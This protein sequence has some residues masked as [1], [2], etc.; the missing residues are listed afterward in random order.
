M[1]KLFVGNLSWNATEDDLK[2]HFESAGAVVS[3][4]IVIDPYTGKSKGFGFVEMQD[5]EGAQKAIQD[6]NETPIADRSIRVSFAFERTERPGGNSGGPRRERSDGG[7]RSEGRGGGG[8]GGYRQ[9][10][11]RTADRNY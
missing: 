5:V 10:R 9:S 8:E 11:S 1:K 6:L 4:K 7:G 3:V 2:K